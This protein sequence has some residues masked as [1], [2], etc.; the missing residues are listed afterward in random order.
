MPPRRGAR[1]AG[2]RQDRHRARAARGRVGSPDAARSEVVRLGATRARVALHGLPR[3]SVAPARPHPARARDRAGAALG[4]DAAGARRRSDMVRQPAL[5][6]APARGGHGP[7]CARRGAR[8]APRV[9][10]LAAP[11]GRRRA[12]HGARRAPGRGPAARGRAARR[13]P[14]AAAA[15][16]GRG[17]GRLCRGLS[18]KQIAA[19]LGMSPHTV[20]DHVKRLHLRFGVQ[21]RGELIARALRR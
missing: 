7:Q 2:R 18:E 6:G 21:S 9:R 17:A 3:R 1:R 5:P 11:G 13:A 12:V 4:A 8:G 14:R 15:E 20:H 16:A 19:E 10:V